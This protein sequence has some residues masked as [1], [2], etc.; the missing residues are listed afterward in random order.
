MKA[1]FLGDSYDVVKQ[2]LIRWL[3]TFGG[4]AVHPMFTERVSPRL[5]SEFSNFLGARL[6]S[7]AVLRS[8]TDRAQYLAPALN[9]DENVFLDPDTGL[10]LKPIQG[11]EAPAYLFAPELVAVASAKP[12]RLVLVFDQSLPRGAE[13]RRVTEKLV[14]LTKEGVHVVAYV[15]HASFLLVGARQ[16]RLAEAFATLI[17]ESRLPTNRFVSVGA[18]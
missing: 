15:S 3:R 13:R 9:T 16:S 5:A 8:R 2:S 6:L 7:Q 11:R 17:A 18:T 14:H 10:R 4:W 1:K 12:E